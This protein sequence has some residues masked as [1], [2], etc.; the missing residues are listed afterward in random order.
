[1][2][3]IMLLKSIIIAVVEGITEFIPVSSTGHMIIV[4]DIIDFKG[5]FA[6]LF[7][8]VIQLGAILAIV[9]LYKNKIFSSIVGVFKGKKEDFR[10][11]L[12]IA[13]ACIPAVILGFAFE[14]AIDKY[15]FNTTTV[16]LALVVGAILMLLSEKRVSCK[17]KTKSVDDITIPQAFKIGVFQCL[18]LWPGMSR[19]ASTIIGGWINGLS[20]VAATEFS[21]FLALPVMVGASGLKIIKYEEV[22]SSGELIILSIGFVVAFLSALVC[23]EKFIGYLK[24]KPMKNFA[25]YRLALAGVLFV[26]AVLGVVR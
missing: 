6:N 5:E 20:T 23:V 7:T 21:F 16:T 25:Y 8:I 11:W 14:D 2:D 22:L 26:L 17:R 13:V 10:F 19:S 3:F 18:A 4:G 24:K 15:L 9:V 1:M 12:N